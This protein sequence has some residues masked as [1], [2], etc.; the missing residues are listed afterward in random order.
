ML[1]Y[2]YLLSGD[3]KGRR[4]ATRMETE[5]VKLYQERLQQFMINIDDIGKLPVRGVQQEI[6][7]SSRQIFGK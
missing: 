1:Y 7:A 3:G 2:D 5:Q 4:G 6:R